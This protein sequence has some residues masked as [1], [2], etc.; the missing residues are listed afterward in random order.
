MSQFAGK[1]IGEKVMWLTCA[2]E[3]E[4]SLQLAWGKR[5]DGY[6][7]I[8]PRVNL[9]NKD[10]DYIEE[11]QAIATELGVPGHIGSYMNKTGVR[12][13][14]W[15]GFK[16][17]QKLLN[18]VSA[19]LC[20]RKRTVAG[21][22]QEF[23]A[24][25]LSLNPHVQY[26]QKEKDLFLE[27]RALNGKGMVDNQL[28]R[29][30]FETPAQEKKKNCPACGKE[31][32]YRRKDHEFCSKRCR[33]SSMQSSTTNTPDAGSSVKIE[34]DLAGDCKKQAEMTCSV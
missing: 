29:C 31:F 3:S 28:L 13:I 33:P 4:G 30:R 20:T 25:R 14:E 23:I 34:S 17:V 21:K 27:V 9:A 12:Y 8:V 15:V 6:I 5:T 10:T 32:V 11:A 1:S 2:I 22:I 16:R 18:I 19:L 26:G 7:Q 24:Y